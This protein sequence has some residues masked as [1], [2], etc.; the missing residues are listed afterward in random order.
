[1]RRP[2]LRAMRV[3]GAGARSAIVAIAS[4][5]W[6]AGCTPV[7]ANPVASS[8]DPRRLLDEAVRALGG[9]QAL[10]ALTTVRRDM[11]DGWV[12]TGQGQH[13]WTGVPDVDHLPVHFPETIES[14]IDYAG[15]RWFESQAFVDAR[16]PTVQIDA[17]DATTGFEA[18]TY[19]DERPYFRELDGSEAAA[20]HTRRLRRFP[21]GMLRMALRA[22]TPQ[23]ADAGDDAGEHH[24]AI[25]FTDPA[26][27]RIVLSFDPV[28]HRL[29]RS[30]IARDHAVLGDTT[31]DTLYADY[32]PVGHLVLPFLQID[33]I[34]G[35]PT[36]RWPIS[37]IDLDGP[38]PQAMMPPRDV[39][40][41]QPPPPAPTLRA[42]QDGVFEILGPYN[43]MFAVFRDHVLLIEAPLGEAYTEAC[44]ALIES[45]APG[46][47]VRAVA[48]H[49]H[50]DHIGGAR[51]LVSLGIPI[52]TTP[53]GAAVIR[54]AVAARHA[55]H[56][57]RLARAPRE[58][59]LEVVEA[60]HVDDDGAQRVEL[61]DVG[62]TPHVAQILVAYFA[63]TRTLLV[64]D[65]LDVLSPEMA[66]PGIDTIALIR[67]LKE[68]HLEVDDFVPV[69]GVPITREDLRRGLAI[70]ARHVPDTPADAR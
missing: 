59:R 58:P 27:T 32:R 6:L 3:P 66:I 23:W 53:D 44:L 1:M 9:A 18:I 45:V 30:R 2:Q 25:A 12:D 28:T 60:R 63:R 46:K 70:R 17:G 42:L 64:P 65:L 35:V 5:M 20:Q 37:R 10:A 69:H 31:A 68:Y 50:Y 67:K 22:Q 40:A 49:F 61:Y 14:F 41:I 43:V 4:A 11:V 56:P 51:T 55:A 33:R 29:T 62:P 36:H 39:V 54:R 48:T 21:E 34:A 52:A 13:P 38:A 16:E 57:D 8:A 24:D 47:P 15:D 7:P 26:G 19:S